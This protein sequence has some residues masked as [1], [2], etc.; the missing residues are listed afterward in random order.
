MESISKGLRFGVKFVPPTPPPVNL[1]NP[2]TTPSTVHHLTK[3]DSETYRYVYHP[4]LGRTG[5]GMY[6]HTEA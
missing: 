6:V 5:S 2:T 3:T 4:G 1:F